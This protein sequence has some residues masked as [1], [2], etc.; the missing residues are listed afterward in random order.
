MVS[1]VAV[2]CHQR[3]GLW[4]PERI[5]HFGHELLVQA[6]ELVHGHGRQ[7]R[8]RKAQIG[9]HVEL[10]GLVVVIK[11]VVATSV[12]DRVNL[13]NTAEEFTP[14]VIAVAGDQRIVEVKQSEGHDAA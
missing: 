13:A 3:L 7:G 4:Q 5:D 1:G 12:L 9:I 10:S 11:L 8:Q 6:P 2:A 14:G